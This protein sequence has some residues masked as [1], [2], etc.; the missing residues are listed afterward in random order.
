MAMWFGNQK[1]RRVETRSAHFN[2]T[3]LQKLVHPIVN[4]LSM[5]KKIQEL[6]H[7]NWSGEFTTT[8]CSMTFVH[9]TSSWDFEH[10]SW[11][12]KMNCQYRRKDSNEALMSRFSERNL[13]SSSDK[14]DAEGPTFGSLGSLEKSEKISSMQASGRPCS[15]ISS[16][17]TGWKNPTIYSCLKNWSSCKSLEK[18]E[19]TLALESTLLKESQT[20][21][22]VCVTRPRALPSHAIYHN[23]NSL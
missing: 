9:P 19:N 17:W 4:C 23:A 11:Y 18:T 8:Y 16:S 2:V 5:F 10:M 1:N 14:G 15:K 13:C 22:Y 12:S 3:F 7:M 21:R 6:S 20:P